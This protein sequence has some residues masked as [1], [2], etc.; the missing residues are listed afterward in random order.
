M[1]LAPAERIAHHRARGWWGDTRMSD[2]FDAHVRR[3]PGA[4][5][6]IDPP[7]TQAIVGRRP[8]SS[9]GRSWTTR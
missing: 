1:I 8:A 6:V 4:P 7:N 3:K 9:P 5:A 2:L